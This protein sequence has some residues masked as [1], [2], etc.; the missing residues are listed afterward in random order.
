MNSREK[1][2]WTMM[3]LTAIGTLML[4]PVSP[5]STALDRLALYW[6]PLQLFIFSHLPDIF[7]RK[8]KANIVWVF[9]VVLYY[10]LVLAVWLFL[11]DN[12]WS[13]LPYKFFLWEWFWDLPDQRFRGF[14]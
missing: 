6:I 11:S 8:G 2:F 4:F 12:S 14:G 5:S 9:L 10:L 1:S 13:W 7:G 3:S